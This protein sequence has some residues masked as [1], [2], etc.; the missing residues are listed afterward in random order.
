M[1]RR[2]DDDLDK[3]TKTWHTH[4]GRAPTRRVWRPRA[5]VVNGVTR[6]RQCLVSFC[7]PVGGG[8]RRSL[9]DTRTVPSGDSDTYE[10]AT[11]KMRRETRATYRDGGTHTQA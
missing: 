7:A 5:P 8:I 4:A 3:S 2:R 11:A 9:I 1:K 10:T 6:P